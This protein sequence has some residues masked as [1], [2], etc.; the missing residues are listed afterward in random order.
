M[1]N[2]QLLNTAL[3]LACLLTL[4]CKKKKVYFNDGEDLS[5]EHIQ[6]SIELQKNEEE[7]QKQEAEAKKKAEELAKEMAILAEKK[8]IEDEARA[9]Q[10]AMDAEIA[11]LKDIEDRQEAQKLAFKNYKGTEYDE[12]KL[13]NGQILTNVKVSKATP[14]KVTF[15]HND[16]VAN[17]KYKDL[18]SDIRKACNFDEELMNLELEKIN[19]GDK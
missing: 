5:L 2:T 1:R 9:K 6:E 11:R 13:L 18:P 14:I 10:E 19:E 16:G 4:S 7:K 3:C 17:V 15:L 12:L 8:R